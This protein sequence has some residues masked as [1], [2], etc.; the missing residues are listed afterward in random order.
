MLILKNA[1][2]VTG[3]GQTVIPNGAVVVEEGRIVEVGDD[4]VSSGPRDTVMD[5][6]GRL[7]IP[8]AVNAHSHA[9]V[10]SPLFASGAPALPR[11]RISTH[12]DKQLLGGTTTVLNVDGFNLP[13][14]VD[15]INQTHPINIKVAT[16]HFPLMI[17]AARQAD[18]SGL[19]SAH[20]QMTVEKMLD[21]GAVAIAELGA[22]H[23][24]AGGGQDY[25][26]IP[27]AIE[28]ETG[29]QLEPKEAQAIK[30]AV[31]GRRVQV[32]AY[33]RAK[34][35]E[36][37]SRVG[38]S[39]RITPERARDIIHE[40][41]LPAFATALEGLLE[42]ARLAV[43]HDTPTMI[44]TSAPSEQAAYD[45]ADIAGPLLVSGHTNH[46]T[47]TVEESVACAER[48]REKGAL[49]EVSTLDAF[50]DKRLVPTPENIYALLERDLVDVVATDYAGG[51][52][53]NIYLGLGHAVADGVVS[54][55]KAVALATR[56]VTVAFPKLAPD[57]GEIAPG[58]IAD[59]VVCNNRLDR[60][61]LVFV[62]G[63]LVCDGGRM[64]SKKE[65]QA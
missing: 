19:T 30:Y 18:G 48:L 29:V 35:E 51:H 4:A 55:P 46:S 63:T 40:C 53:D 31:L 28:R 13:E 36:T 56:N 45:A 65:V 20:E 64:L 49:I 60:V 50:G 41:V 47:F 26:Y 39:D 59:L 43:K 22:G 34:V 38:L 5:L 62:N 32:E 11:E 1:M 58:K 2:I 54:L 37:L 12:L 9:N 57:R 17:E 10:T 42:G 24:L 61:D 16:T 44:H 25:M 52:W 15:P 27:M 33:D 14:E 21:Y 7:L 8:G 6:A 3:D 23:T